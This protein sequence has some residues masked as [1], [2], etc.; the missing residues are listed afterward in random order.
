MFSVLFEG[1]PTHPEADRLWQIVA[2]HRVTQFYTGS[3]CA[4]CANVSPHCHPCA[5]AIWKLL[6]RPPRPVV[7]AYPRVGGRA[8]QPR[9]MA[10][11][12]SFLSSLKV[13]LLFIAVLVQYMLTFQVPYCHWTRTVRH[14]GHV[15]ADGNWGAHADP[16][17]GSDLDQARL[18]G[19]LAACTLMTDLAHVWCRPGD[20]RCQ[21]ARDLGALLGL[22]GRVA[23]VAGTSRGF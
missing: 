4:L 22:P 16:A 20:P 19:L 15:V 3:P 13:L 8:H 5:A 9:S 18:G 21:W 1:M 11:V 7:A 6:P 12:S 17:S 14:C 23:L 10:L 2:K